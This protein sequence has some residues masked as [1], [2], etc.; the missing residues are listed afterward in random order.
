[1]QSRSRVIARPGA[2]GLMEAPR[3]VRI[4]SDEFSIDFPLQLI[5]KPAR[6]VK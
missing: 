1:L 4:A 3:R 5:L 2:L 6:A